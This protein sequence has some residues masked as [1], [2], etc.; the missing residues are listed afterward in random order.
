MD[1]QSVVR[2]GY[3]AIGDRYLKTF[4]LDASS[5]RV[6][7]LDALLRLLRPASAAL[8][9]G[10]GPGYPVTRAL[11][12]RCSV[13]A[14]DISRTQ[15]DLAR[16]HAPGATLVQADMCRLH[17]QPATFDA[18]VAFYSLTHVPRD[19]HRE[20]LAR[21]ASW[22]RPRGLLVATMGAGDIPAS[23]ERDW[24]G[25]PMFFSHFDAD[26]NMRLVRDAGLEVEEQDVVTEIEHDGHEVA[27]LWLVARRR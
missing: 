26:T 9:L 15:L 14:V 22:V 10:C 17:F 7:Y 4:A 23:F 18:V 27:F 21:I 1:P 16:R 5:P 11:A 6:R 25:A 12:E 3:D 2:R 8:E 20:L 24:L 13:V 19:E